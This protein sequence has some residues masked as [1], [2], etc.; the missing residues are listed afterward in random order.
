MNKLSA[1]FSRVNINPM[2]GMGLSGYY[3]VRISEGVADDLEATALALKTEDTTV[4]LIS[5]DVIS[6]PT[7]VA[8][9]YREAIAAATGLPKEAI[10]LHGTHIHSG[11]YLYHPKTG[12][13][14]PEGH[15]ALIDEYL[16]FLGHRLVDVALAAIE[17]LA[18]ARMGF[19]VGRAENIS[20]IRRF[21]MKD[22]SIRTNPGLGNPD[23]LEPLGTVEER[24]TSVRF[25]REGKNNILLFHFGTHPDV[26]GGRRFSADWP[27]FARRTLEAALPGTSAIFFNGA[28]GD[29]NHINVNLANT[30]YPDG[31]R[32]CFGRAT[33]YEHARHMGRALAGSILAVYDK[34]IY[35]DVESLTFCE[36]TV[37][38]FANK[39]TPEQLPEAH[40]IADLYDAGRANEL[41]YEGMERTTVIAEACRMVALENKP[42]TFEMPMI[43]LAI[44]DV[45]IVGLPGEIFTGIGSGIRAAEGEDFSLVLPLCLVNGSEGY[46]PMKDAYDEGGYEAKTSHYKSGTAEKMIE[47]GR[48]ILKEIGK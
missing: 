48:S 27:G 41:P 4:L 10:L 16:A 39:G 46:F 31:V 37:S 45:A 34:P 47:D 6:F 38:Y 3:S 43:A 7:S 29:V 22:G 18:P 13:P 8:H 42:D 25:D 2:L 9:R 30:E 40:R 12:A 5:A 15:D 26:V 23:I 11:P 14:H 24:A 44:G 21:R 19:S 33:G 35:R 32:M 28:Q 17:D 20:F 36:K 1:G